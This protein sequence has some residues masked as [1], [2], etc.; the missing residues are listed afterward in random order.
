V[1]GELF[2]S[3]SF[4]RN[5]TEL[6]FLATVKVVEPLNPDQLPRLPGVSELKP[7]NSPPPGGA[8]PSSSI[9]GQSGHSLPQKSGEQQP[10]GESKSKSEQPVTNKINNGA[11]DN[12]TSKLVP[13]ATPGGPS[14]A[15]GPESQAKN[16]DDGK[17]SAS[18][19]SDVKDQKPAP[20]SD[21]P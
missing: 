12:L 14:G 6:L 11:V 2:K 8:T 15:T 18:P 19:R 1:L 9:D 17:K 7:V 13:P 21:K 3:R 5:E 16:S 20:G 4:Q 10:E